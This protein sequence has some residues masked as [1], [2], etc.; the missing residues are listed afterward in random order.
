MIR[1]RYGSETGFLERLCLRDLNHITAL[2]DPS[3][4][5]NLQEIV[6]ENVPIDLAKLP[7]DLQKITHY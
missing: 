5:K 2:P 4:L 1:R 7:I 3:G 6:L